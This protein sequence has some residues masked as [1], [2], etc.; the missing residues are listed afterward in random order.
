MFA[1]TGNSCQP[2]FHSLSFPQSPFTKNY[3]FG[4]DSSWF[5]PKSTLIV[6]VSIFFMIYH[7]S[8]PFQKESWSQYAIPFYGKL[9]FF[10]SI[11]FLSYR[12]IWRKKAWKL[13]IFMWVL[14]LIG[15]ESAAFDDF[16]C[17]PKRF[18]H[19]Y[20]R[21]YDVTLTT[22]TVLF[23]YRKEKNVSYV[24]IKMIKYTLCSCNTVP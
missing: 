5:V 8:A 23:F 4:N 3:F 1:Y 16:Y 22:E 2:S 9:P 15:N 13:F 10:L 24:F 19:H 6:R 11:T 14:S 20:G 7:N 21:F 18:W 17:F 12:N